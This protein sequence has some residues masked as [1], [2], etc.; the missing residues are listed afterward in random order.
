MCSSEEIILQYS[1]LSSNYNSIHVSFSPAHKNVKVFISH[2]G[3]LGSQEA[4]YH[5]T[6][7]IGMPLIGDQ[8]R[9]IIKWQDRGIARAVHWNDLTEEHLTE[10]INDVMNNPKYVQSL[11]DMAYFTDPSQNTCLMMLEGLLNDLKAVTLCEWIAISSILNWPFCRDV[12][13][14]IN[15]E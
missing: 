8:Q 15:F 11:R 9:N 2:C 7:I 13:H 14:S 4:M 5:A 12:L 6:P 1:Y 3:L 10:A